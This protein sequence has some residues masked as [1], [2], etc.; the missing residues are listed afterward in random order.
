M[1]LAAPWKD[2]GAE[3]LVPEL[4]SLPEGEAK[5]V[6]LVAV[7][8]LLTEISTRELVAE[9]PAESL[10]L[11]ERE[12][13]PSERELVLRLTDQLVVPEAFTKAPPS[14]DSCTEL[15]VKPSEAT[16][17]TEIVPETVELLAGLEM[18]TE[19]AA[20][21]T[22]LMLRLAEAEVPALSLTAAVKADE[23]ETVGVPEMAPEE[24]KVRP[25]GSD[26]FESDHE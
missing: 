1:E 9:L 26:P 7:E 4:E 15:I 25:G 20:A 23:P 3:E 6:Q 13:V 2:L 12:W 11:A 10:T 21:V 8:A 24:D 22:T 16:P 14:T 18:E 19:G 5:S 17:E